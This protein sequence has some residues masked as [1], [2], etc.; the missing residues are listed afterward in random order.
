MRCRHRSH[1]QPLPGG[2]DNVSN[3]Y[4]S[5]PLVSRKCCP[6]NGRNAR[7]K[8]CRCAR[9]G[10]ACTDCYPTRHGRCGNTH[11]AYEEVQT[12]VEIPPDIS[13]SVSQGSTGAGFILEYLKR[14]KCPILKNIPKAARSTCASVFTNLMR[15]II[16]SPEDDNLWVNFFLFPI[17]CLRLPPR[18]TKISLASYVLSKTEAFSQKVEFTLPTLPSERRNKL[19][20]RSV[21]ALKNLVCE[22]FDQCDIRGAMRLLLAEDSVAPNDEETYASLLSKHPGRF[23]QTPLLDRLELPNSE[24][25]YISIELIEE[26]LKS[27]PPGS[28]GGID[29]LRPQHLKDMFFFTSRL[30]LT[31]FDFSD[32]ARLHQPH[33][34]RRPHR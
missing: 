12:A 30:E 21:N 23:T 31:K 29:G 24:A 1:L 20:P 15:A 33:F 26:C 13:T 27:F 7:C 22:K 6:C 8:G 25:G 19:K 34:Q 10:I 5:Q 9:A 18:G 11:V 14:H 2:P 4:L 28:S 16:L 3:E 32:A 17:E